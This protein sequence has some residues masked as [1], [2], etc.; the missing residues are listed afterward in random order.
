MHYQGDEEQALALGEESLTIFRRI[1]DRAGIGRALH[2]V[3][4][5]AEDRGDYDRATAFFEEA[6]ALHRADNEPR[7]DRHDLGTS[8]SSPTAGV[9]TS[10]RPR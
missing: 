10:G 6:L 1:G 7:V 8:G 5:V 2:L 3:G 9:T 4:V